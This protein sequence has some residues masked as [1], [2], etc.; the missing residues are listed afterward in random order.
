MLLS[1][2][3]SATRDARNNFGVQ[4]GAQLQKP[5]EIMN[6]TARYLTVPEERPPRLW[7]MLTR[8]IGYEF[9][10]RATTRGF[11]PGHWP[12]ES[13]IA[14]FKKQKVIV[15][16]HVGVYAER[17]KRTRNIGLADHAATIIVEC[18]QMVE[19]QLGSLN[20][21][22]VPRTPKCGPFIHGLTRQNAA[23]CYYVTA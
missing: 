5:L 13:S 8:L 16:L 11:L 12:R 4:A 2:V 1:A 17:V 21:R 7:S 18:V 20:K 23:R 10:V 6:R 3:P 19:L 9:I 14:I 15:V 22:P